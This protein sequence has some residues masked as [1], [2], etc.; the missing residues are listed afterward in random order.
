MFDSAPMKVLAPA[1]NSGKKVHPLPFPVYAG[2]FF[3]LILAGIVVSGYLAISHYRVYTDM[4][5]KSFC[6]I[7]RAINCDTV[8]QSPHSIFLG[9]P[10]PVWGVVGYTLLL[11]LFVASWKSRSDQLRLWAV[12][13]WI[14]AGYTLYSIYLAAVSS[15]VIHSYCLMCIL[16]YGVNVFLCWFAW[17]IH[18]RF[19]DRNLLAGTKADLSLLWN[20]RPYLLALSAGFLTIIFFIKILLPTYWQYD[21]PPLTR[22]IPTGIS[23]EGHPWIGADSPQLVIKEYADYRC[24][25]CKKMH[26]F[27]R[28]LIAD[29]PE[30]IR[31]VHHHFP[32]DHEI[33]PIVKEP[34]H[35]GSAALARIAIAAGLHGKFWEAND[36]LFMQAREED[37]IDLGRLAEDI[38]LDLDSLLKTARGRETLLVLVRDVRLG[39]KQRITGTPAYVVDGQVHQGFIP[40]QIIASLVK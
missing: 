29:H 11:P 5:Y 36:W 21:P 17:L 19:A 13:F 16:L 12:C 9:L 37:E 10:L 30:R 14:A 32:M 40:S 2:V 26:F 33:N 23:E 18:D 28:Q 34:F 15:F 4:A 20:Q 6:A 7:S 31:L 25:Q 27:L 3:A 39:L 22:S 35:V 1:E 24:F 8:S 38:G